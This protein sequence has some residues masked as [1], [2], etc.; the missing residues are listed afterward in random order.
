VYH[1]LPYRYNNTLGDGALITTAAD[2]AR[3]MAMLLGGGALDG[4]RV[5]SGASVGDMLTRRFTNHP[6]LPGVTL[7][8]FEGVR[9]GIP[10]L[11]HEGSMDE[12][13]ESL[14]FLVPEDQIGL[15]LV[16]NQRNSNLRLDL[17]RSFF[18]R[19]YPAPPAP[20]TRRP[21][22]GI[23]ALSGR[24]GH[25]RHPKAIPQ[26]WFVPRER[27]TVTAL[28]D[29]LR[30]VFDGGSPTSW[31]P[32]GQDLFGR[33]G[34]AARVAFRRD[35]EGRPLY[36]FLGVDAYERLSGWSSVLLWILSIAIAAGGIAA[37]LWRRRTSSRSAPLGGADV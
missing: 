23:P 19:F 17:L 12:G 26:R 2:I 22:V 13:F 8:F 29:S 20:L 35:A 7:G 1:L 18:D 16:Y 36:M 11:L 27:A 33:E 28:D 6:A 21:S 5:L 31:V 9:N 3:F 32:I 4:V 15:F 14:L 10:I 24:Y 30:I 25:V 34:S 37:L